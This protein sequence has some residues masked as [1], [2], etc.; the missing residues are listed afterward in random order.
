M[1]QYATMTT[2]D[3]DLNQTQLIREAEEMEKLLIP[4]S[5]S[6]ST[7]QKESDCIICNTSALVDTFIICSLC[8]TNVHYICTVN[9][10]F[11]TNYRLRCQTLESFFEAF[12]IF[13]PFKKLI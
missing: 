12:D 10:S 2:C 5:N 7:S 1:P 9:L 8:S 6:S 3:S 11:L 4:P 13:S